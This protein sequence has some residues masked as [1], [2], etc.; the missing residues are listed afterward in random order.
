MDADKQ[1]LVMPRFVPFD[2]PIFDTVGEVIDCFRQIFEGIQFMHENF[3]AHRDCGVLNFVLDPQEMFPH[4]I[5][6]VK[7][8]ANPTND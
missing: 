7:F 8:W 4:G 2:H 6:P 5:H 3:V 1:I